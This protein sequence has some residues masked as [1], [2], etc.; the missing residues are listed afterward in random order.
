M[1]L[2]LTSPDL[3]VD[4]GVVGLMSFVVGGVAGDGGRTE[5]QMEADVE[6]S[7]QVDSLNLLIFACLLILTVLTIWMFKHIRLRFVHETG[8]AIIYGMLVCHG[9]WKQCFHTR[10]LV[11]FV[12][13]LINKNCIYQLLLMLIVFGQYEPCSKV[14]E[15]TQV[16]SN[17]NHGRI[18][19]GDITTMYKLRFEHRLD[20]PIDSRQGFKQCLFNV[21]ILLPV[22]I[23][24]TVIER[25]KQKTFNYFQIPLSLI[26]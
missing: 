15:T 6:K 12:D 11:D 20:P 17:V 22:N 5:M 13:I 19:P 7:H 23:T 18:S 16:P 21:V 4:V 26:G 1:S 14:V 8:L 25:H 2:K 9:V 3:R 10:L 24:V